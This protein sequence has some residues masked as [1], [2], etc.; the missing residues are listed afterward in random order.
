[1]SQKRL[2]T[3]EKSK[4]GNVD[5]TNT[6]TLLKKPGLWDALPLE[7]RQELYAMLPTPADG[8]T[9]HDPAMNPLR[10]EHHFYIEEA[11]RKW[12]DDLKD[13]KEEKKWRQDAMKASVDRKEGKFNEWRAAERERHWGVKDEGEGERDDEEEG[14]QQ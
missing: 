7:K 13:G 10:S 9:P 6:Q 11:L 8:Q 14:S 5:L 12:Q 3:S 2:L 4:L 1:M